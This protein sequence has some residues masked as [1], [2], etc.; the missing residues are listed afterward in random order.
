M[1]ANPPAEFQCP[2]CGMVLSN[3]IEF[4]EHQDVHLE[5]RA[6]GQ[7]ELPVHQ[8]VLCSARFRTPEELRDHHRTAHNR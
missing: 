5:E 7:S 6:E 3:E 4:S 2:V 1:A 8:C